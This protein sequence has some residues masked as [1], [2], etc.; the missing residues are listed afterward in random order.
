MI[1]FDF[2]KCLNGKFMQI[3]INIGKIKKFQNLSF[4]ISK[5]KIFYF[6]YFKNLFI[7]LN[8]L[9]GSTKLFKYLHLFCGISGSI[10]APKKISLFKE[11]INWKKKYVFYFQKKKKHL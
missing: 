2:K 4:E 9:R 11:Y 3:F 7:L 1:P 10:F 5:L 8:T 6:F